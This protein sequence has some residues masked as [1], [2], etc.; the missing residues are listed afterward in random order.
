M[1][2]SY[3]WH[4]ALLTDLAE[5]RERG[6]LPAAIGI[7]CPAGWAVTRCWPERHAVAEYGTDKEL[8]E[9][10]HP[11][12][13]WIVPDGAVIKIDQVRALNAFACKRRKLPSARWRL[14]SMLIC[15]M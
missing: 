1:V 8:E 10:A 7:S 9:I 3:P 15:S 4:E 2:E 11:D 5:R 14:C 12:F 13:R 6:R